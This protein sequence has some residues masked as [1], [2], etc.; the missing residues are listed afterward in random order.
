MTANEC[1]VLTRSGCRILDL[2]NG[3][4]QQVGL[5]LGVLNRQPHMFHSGTV[6]ALGGKML[7]MR[8]GPS[9]QCYDPVTRSW[10]ELE[11]GFHGP[12]VPPPLHSVAGLKR[13]STAVVNLPAL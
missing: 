5:D 7:L 9:P 2:R 4:V 6:A 3:N 10:Q 12:H 8:V 11:C 13:L 1:F